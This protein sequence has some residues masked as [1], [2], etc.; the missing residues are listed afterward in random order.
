MNGFGDAAA[1]ETLRKEIAD[2]HKV[3][4]IYNGADMSKGEAVAAL[5]ADAE[6]QL[7]Q[8]DI[9][10]N[11]AGIQFVAPTEEFP[12]EKW[13]AIIAINLSASFHAIRASLPGM[14]KRGWGRI[15]NIASAH[16]LVASSGKAAYVAAKHGLLGLTNSGGARSGE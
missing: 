12:V 11:N 1:I 6:K 3:K 10:V 7:G 2:T 9:L 15:V 13:D 16:A 14:K 4:V 8:L 5:V